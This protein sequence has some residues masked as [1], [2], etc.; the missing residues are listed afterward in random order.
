MFA[1]LRKN[2]NRCMSLVFLELLVI[3]WFHR[4]HGELFL[5]SELIALGIH[6]L[7]SLFG[8]CF[9]VM[10]RSKLKIS[11][12]KWYSPK[13]IFGEIILYSVFDFFIIHMILGLIMGEFEFHLVEYMV[14]IMGVIIVNLVFDSSKHNCCHDHCD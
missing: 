3:G 11:T 6:L 7:L 8:L 1:L 9:Y 12:T 14:L 2:A 13:R 10:M 5:R 4:Y